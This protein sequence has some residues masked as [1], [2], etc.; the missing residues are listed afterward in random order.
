MK[1]LWLTNIPLPEACQ[2]MN[3]TPSP[4]GG[5]L[6]N[7]SNSL[8]TQEDIELS[9]A[10]PK[11]KSKDVIQ[12]TGENINYFS[13]PTVS[14]KDESSIQ[15]NSYIKSI[16]KELKPDLVHAFGTEFAHTLAM[17]NVC[18]A[19]GIKTVISIQGLVSVYSK[20]YT[21]NLPIKV[22]KR[23]TFK[24]WIKQSNLIQQQKQ[25]EKKGVL[26]IEA[27]QKTDHIIGR[28]TW[29]KGCTEQ[30]N[31]TA[32]YHFCNETLREEFYKH[33]WSIDRCEKHSIFLSQAGYPIKGLHYVLEAMPL[34]Q[35][36]F[37]DTKLY[38]AG[39]DITSS[40]TLNE[41]LRM[42]SY[43]KYIAELI[44]S[45]NLVDSVSFTGVLDE[46]KMCQ[47]YLSSNVFVSPSSIE[48]SPNSLG[49]AMILG[50]PCVASHVGGVPDMIK[51]NEEGYVYQADAPYMLAHY[52]CEV[53]ESDERALRFSNNSRT[54]AWKTHNPKI[55]TDRLIEIYKEI[56]QKKETSVEN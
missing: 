24:D 13:F 46:K 50:V 39:T 12:L 36:K 55:N 11:S 49:E 28:T 53:F 44:E 23:F 47:R 16:V 26:E 3:E 21:A 8:S 15:D 18:K 1:I 54:H 14:M 56:L 30:I 10:F 31:P 29:D 32:N 52:V 4:F 41:K 27:I 20:H 5:W 25:F 43:A 19:L 22:Q 9:I 17:M 40:G 6:I 42:S 35:Q 2:L 37:P 33:K 51:H 45:Y 38:I 7:A 34:I 48:N